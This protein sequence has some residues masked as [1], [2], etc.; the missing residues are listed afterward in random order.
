MDLK[1]FEHQILHE[2]RA[3][4]DKVV[5]IGLEV[6]DFVDRDKVFN[7]LL[8]VANKY[9]K[10]FVNNKSRK[11]RKWRDKQINKIKKWFKF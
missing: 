11:V 8:K 6:G 3:L 5:A 4:T 2:V 1:D 7:Q 10:G 9:G